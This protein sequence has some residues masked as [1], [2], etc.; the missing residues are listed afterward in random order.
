MAGRVV[1]VPTSCVQGSCEAITSSRTTEQAAIGPS[2]RGS[3]VLGWL[4]QD[5]HRSQLLKAATLSGL[6][7]EPT[8]E[9]EF[10]GA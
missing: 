1:T 3:C 6:N 7:Q 8:E 5:A 2:Q 10:Q 4:C 9:T